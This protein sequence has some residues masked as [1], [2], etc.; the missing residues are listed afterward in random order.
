MKNQ[1]QIATRTIQ[2]QDDDKCSSKRESY[3]T[4]ST[5]ISIKWFG[6]QGK[7]IAAFKTQC[8][9]CIEI[10]ILSYAKFFHKV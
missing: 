1:R 5:E 2:Y 4:K 6:F 3:Q 7:A 8:C 10:G 9:H